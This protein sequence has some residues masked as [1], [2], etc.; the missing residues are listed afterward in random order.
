MIISRG[1]ANIRNIFYK[2][3]NLNSSALYNIKIT[4]LNGKRYNRKMYLYKILFKM[5]LNLN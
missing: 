5:I 1:G 2:L 3:I 4:K